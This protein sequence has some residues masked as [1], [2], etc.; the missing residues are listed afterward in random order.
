MFEKISSIDVSGGDPEHKQEVEREEEQEEEPRVE[1]PAGLAA[2]LE[3]AGDE[4]NPEAFAKLETQIHEAIFLKDQEIDRLKRNSLTGL[5]GRSEFFDQAEALV[6]KRMEEHDSPFV[7][8][9]I[10]HLHGDEYA[11]LFRV[12]GD[13]HILFGDMAR[14][15]QW[16]DFAGHEKGGDAALQKVG[17]VFRDIQAHGG[18]DPSEKVRAV[19]ES[20]YSDSELN[21]MSESEQVQAVYDQFAAQIYLLSMHRGV[22]LAKGVDKAPPFMLDSGFASFAEGEEARHQLVEKRVEI[23]KEVVQSN[24][25]DQITNILRQRLNGAYTEDQF[26]SILGGEDVEAQHILATEMAWHGGYENQ[27]VALTRDIAEFRAN[28]TKGFDAVMDLVDEY[29]DIMDEKISDVEK[30]VK[31]NEYWEDQFKYMGKSL[32]GITKGEIADLSKNPRS[33]K[34]YEML[35]KKFSDGAR[36]NDSGDSDY[37]PSAEICFRISKRYQTPTRH[38]MFLEKI[39]QEE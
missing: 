1:L 30:D 8:V 29:T 17:D 21:A 3:T 38:S 9:E 28:V 26:R 4:M 7:I 34:L 2:I 36:E 14:L 39:G 11:A 22:E 27:I 20:M 15:N 10:F 37:A 32:K 18:E 13:Y 31:W 5:Y 24:D 19:F 33:E 23:L 16:N 12:G 35:Y 6:D 25:V